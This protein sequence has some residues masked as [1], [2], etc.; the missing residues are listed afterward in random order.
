M[1][2]VEDGF[3]L[4]RPARN[5]LLYVSDDR[6]R[7]LRETA[8]NATEFATLLVDVPAGHDETLFLLFGDW[9]AWCA[10][11]LLA[12]VVGR[13]WVGPRQAEAM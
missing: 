8:S 7:V 13:V 11:V 3:S 12:L 5:G 1:R 6:G 10:A 4:V 9:F 2:A